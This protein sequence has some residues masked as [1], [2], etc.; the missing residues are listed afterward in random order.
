MWWEV[1]WSQWHPRM[2]LCYFPERGKLFLRCRKR[3]GCQ[4][5]E[6]Q[7][8][9]DMRVTAIDEWVCYR[10]CLTHSVGFSC[11]P[12][13]H[14]TCLEAKK[15]I[16]FTVGFDSSSP[17]PLLG[18]RK[19]SL[20]VGRFLLCLRAAL[21]ACQWTPAQWNQFLNDKRS[22]NGFCSISS[23]DSGAF[24]L[25]EGKHHYPVTTSKEKAFTGVSY[26]EGIWK[27]QSERALGICKHG[28]CPG[29]PEQGKIWEWLQL[30]LVRNTLPC[31]PSHNCQQL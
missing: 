27:Q 17:I 10:L 23:T 4:M 21:M 19:R 1:G 3:C 24:H 8:Q 12:T 2:K 14:P 7:K 6:H 5:Q 13:L 9:W 15:K 16:S 29:A 20:R 26:T 25:N 28:P 31:F 18:R 22:G 30:K 11:F